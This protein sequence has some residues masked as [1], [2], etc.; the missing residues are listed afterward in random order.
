MPSTDFLALMDKKQDA[1]IAFLVELVAPDGTSYDVTEFYLSGGEMSQTKQRA[2]DEIEAGTFDVVFDNS[3]NFFCEFDTASIFY[4]VQYQGSWMVR[5]SQGF[6][7]PDG[8]TEYAPQGVG[9]IDDLI[10]SDATSQVTI[11]CSDRMGKVISGELRNVTNLETPVADAANSGDGTI[12]SI[13]T[14]PFTVASEDWT[15]TCTTPGG[16]G[17]GQFS[18]VG[19]VSGN[20]GTAT[21]GT[22]FSTSANPG[23]IQ[24]T[25]NAGGSPWAS[26]D[27]FTFS[28]AAAPAWTDANPA[29]ILWEMLTGYSWDTNTALPF[30]AYLLDFDHTQSSANTDLDYDSFS[31][32]VAD[33]DSAGYSVTGYATYNQGASEFATSL[34]LLFLGA[35]FTGNDG[36]IRL[37][38]FAP[39]L[40]TE[41]Y[42]AFADTKQTI[43][44]G[45]ERALSEIINRV[46]V[47]YKSDLDWAFSA[48]PE[49]LG[50]TYTVE[51]TDA[52]AAT[53][54]RVIPQTF[55]VPWYSSGGTA[56]KAFAQRLIDRYAL[57]PINIT[58]ATGHD[59]LLTQIGDRVSIT[60]AKHRMSVVPGE[61]STIERDFES[62]PRRIKITLRRDL[63]VSLRWS[64]LGSSADE[65]DG[66]SPQNSNW[67]AASETD[68][69]FA[70]LG[71]ELESLKTF[72]YAADDLPQNET[73]P[74]TRTLSSGV[75]NTESAS[76]GALNIDV[77][78][79]SLSY[80]LPIG[81]LSP[82]DAFGIDL[83]FSTLGSDGSGSTF[84]F[85]VRAGGRN[86]AF[87]F[88]S[89]K[90]QEIAGT[91]VA[92][93]RDCRPA[94][95][96]RFV[97]KNDLTVD[98]YVDEVFVGNFG[99]GG[100]S[101]NI[102][103]VMFFSGT[104]AGAI[105]SAW[106]FRAADGVLIP[107]P[108]YRLF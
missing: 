84:Q 52:Q 72:E 21:S 44:C 86:Y 62:S 53:N 37:S 102:D 79:A 4:G 94:A 78:G 1:P 19:S 46:V 57:A 93:S 71:S 61:V 27:K 82:G 9:I 67:D 51:D 90:L 6:V 64:F 26:G 68:R 103:M 106:Y 40:V 35:M 87:D 16:D 55:S 91:T 83:S 49:N 65:G 50:G 30:S 54:G 18:V 105:T 48:S 95:S 81:D 39:R 58:F 97:I 20:V 32:A 24:F 76:G 7:L 41:Q 77:T 56:V 101:T 14:R 104:I 25:I 47:N 42:R 5:V 34:V 11:R 80:D 88:S 15:I 38:T 36:R 13:E 74:W 17:V 31:K 98:G 63:D 69:L 73:P 22:R 66:I 85:S 33:L 23:G 108:D 8:S 96:Y 70:Y 45:Y 2:P 10:S 100:S 75:V 43:S 107:H 12:S 59:G 92:F 99:S 3:T 28:T 89:T 29:K 60:D